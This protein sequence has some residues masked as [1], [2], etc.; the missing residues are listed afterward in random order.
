MPVGQELTALDIYHFHQD[1]N[2]DGR[3]FFDQVLS[4]IA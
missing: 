2:H 3:C 4:V 1:P